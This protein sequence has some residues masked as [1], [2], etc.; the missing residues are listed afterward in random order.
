MV[1]IAELSAQLASIVE[2]CFQSFTN[3]LNTF[4]TQTANDINVINQFAARVD[5]YV[6]ILF[7]YENVMKTL[8][9]SDQAGLDR[10]AKIRNFVEQTQTAVRNLQTQRLI[11]T[12]SKISPVV[13]PSGN[14]SYDPNQILRQHY[15]NKVFMHVSFDHMSLIDAQILARSET[16]YVGE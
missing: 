10:I 5:G 3:E 9:L 15:E 2:S 13:P 7:G 12:L 14:P 16:G 6:W 11:D 1:E 8:K 4:H